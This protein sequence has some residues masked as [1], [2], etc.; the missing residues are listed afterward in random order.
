MYS[1]PF[2]FL[3]LITE[4]H[5]RKLAAELHGSPRE[6]VLAIVLTSA[7][8]HRLAELS[9]TPIALVNWANLAYSLQSMAVDY[10][11]LGSVAQMDVFYCTPLVVAASR[12]QWLEE[13]L[14]K[15]GDFVRGDVKFHE[16][17]GE[18]YTMIDKEHVFAFQ[19][20]LK[21]VLRSRGL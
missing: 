18:H 4:K 8:P 21:R 2:V 17:D 6:E 14:T 19:K 11:P 1:A 16:V 12:K 20:I 10:E 13:H 15:W 9:L 7:D 3:E 5:S